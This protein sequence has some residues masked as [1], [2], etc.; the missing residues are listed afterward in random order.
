M[1]PVGL[2]RSE[3][4][5]KTND[6]FAELRAASPHEWGWVTIRLAAECGSF[7][8]EGLWKCHMCEGGII[9]LSQVVSLVLVSFNY[10]VRSKSLVTHILLCISHTS[11]NL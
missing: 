6:M 11:H 10:P 1:G 4:D 7:I 8:T 9:N 5:V 2:E 3:V